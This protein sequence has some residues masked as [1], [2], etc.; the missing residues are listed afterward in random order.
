MVKFHESLSDRSVYMRFLHPMLLSASDAAHERLSRI[1]HG[2]YDR[3][4]TLVADRHVA[5]EDGLRIT[6]PPA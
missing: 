2:D 6:A 3:E 5:D 1:A 4:I